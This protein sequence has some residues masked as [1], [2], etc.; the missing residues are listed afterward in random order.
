MNDMFKFEE[1]YKKFKE[2]ADRTKEAYDFWTK[3]VLSTWEDFYSSN[4]KKK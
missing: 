1:Q 2:V 3:L 4:S